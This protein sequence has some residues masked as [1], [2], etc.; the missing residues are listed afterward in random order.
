MNYFKNKIYELNAEYLFLPGQ[1]VG[2]AGRHSYLD[3]IITIKILPFQ[4]L[5]IYNTDPMVSLV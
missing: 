1:H 2:F 5:I 3:Y 4:L